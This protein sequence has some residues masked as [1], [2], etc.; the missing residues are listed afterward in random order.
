[1]FDEETLSALKRCLTGSI[2]K[3]TTSEYV[4]NEETKKMVMVKQKVSEKTIPPNPD[5]MKLIFQKL[6]DE[7]TDY[8]SLSDEE[9][10]K[11]KLRLLRELKVMEENE[12]K[13]KKNDSGKSKNAR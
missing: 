4:L 10:K 6:N 13:E 1:M 5:L 12:I 8:N 2:C 9:L 7:Q 3:E 11:E